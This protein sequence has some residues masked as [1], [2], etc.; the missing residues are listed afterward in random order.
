MNAPFRR[1]QSFGRLAGV[2]R[3]R[4]LPLALAVALFATT[5]AAPCP[6]EPNATT[7]PATRPATVLGT[8]TRPADAR[9]VLG[10][11]E[12]AFDGPLA[13]RRVVWDKLHAFNPAA[14]VK[15]GKIVLLFRAED[16][17]GQMAIG[18]HTSRIGYAASD[19]GID[20]T[21]RDAPVLYPADDAQKANE[22][23]GGCEDPR[24]VARPDGKGWLMTYTQWN[25]KRP[26]LAVATSADL[27][28]WEK[29]GPAFAEYRDA[30]PGTKSGAIVCRA[31]G[32]ELVAAKIAGKYWMYWGEGDV[33]LAGSDDLI[34]WQIV[35]GE[36]GEPLKVLPRR[37]GRFDSALAE[38]GPPAVVVGDRIV[39]LYN[40]KNATDGGGD[41]S[42]GRGAYSGG[43]AL[44]DAAD[45][46]KLVERA[47]EPFFAPELP[48][49]KTGQYGAGTTFIEGLVRRDGRWF[50]YYGC[51]DSYVGVA[52]TAGDQRAD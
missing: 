36:G 16:D 34:S 9:P 47:D 13:G 33:L 3:L 22:W 49:E 52:R 10:P 2:N 44:F 6:A 45:P 40:G 7:T 25:R 29:H 8:F 27:L 19:D 46:A 28:T 11:G 51:A 18:S 12:H 38:G 23:P 37:P 39:V 4:P 50:L 14:A 31:E 32:D 24:V 15:D 26:Q 42:L 30:G 17:A 1:K 48:W 41:P 21:V 20:F 5:R 35:K 43:Q